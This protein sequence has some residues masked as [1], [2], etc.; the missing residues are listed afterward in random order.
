MNVVLYVT[1]FLM[2]ILFGSFYTL[3]VYRIPRKID[4]VK[5][6]SFCPNCKHKLGFS[7]LIPVFSYILLGGKCKQ[8]K[9]K[10]RPRY[11]ILEILSG[12]TF[13]LIALSVNLEIETLTVNLAI[14]LL[15]IVLYLAAIFIIAGIDEENRNIE[16]GLIYYAL[17]ILMA[18]IIYLCIV[19]INSIYRYVMYLAIIIILLIIDTLKLKTKAKSNYALSILILVMIMAVFT[20][21][22]ATIW[23]IIATLLIIAITTLVYEIKN[24]KNKSKKQNIKISENLHIGFYLCISNVVCVILVLFINNWIM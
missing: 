15:F 3:A 18:Y 14:E 16:K 2:G 4:I 21:E 17:G 9:Q 24:R 8:C 11:F 1:I 20:G 5:T 23:S 19:D 7:E 22:V 12:I 10:I 13:I 6:H